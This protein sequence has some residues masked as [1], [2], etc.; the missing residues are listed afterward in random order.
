VNPGSSPHHSG[1]ATGFNQCGVCHSQQ[2]HAGKVACGSCH[3]NA[4][5]FHLYQADSPGFRNCS[6][7]HTMRHA[8]KRIAQSK[9]AAC[10]KGSN[11]RA[12]QHSSSITRKF[13]CSGCHSKALH[14]SRVSKAVSSCRTCHGGRYHAAQKTP[15]RNVCTRCHTRALSHTNGYQC[16]LCHRRAVHNSRPNPHP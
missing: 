5:A 14:A 10:H 2:K 9:C 1:Q 11:G 3:T 6:G 16:T 13:V 7:C 8:G 4:Q 12:A 15:S